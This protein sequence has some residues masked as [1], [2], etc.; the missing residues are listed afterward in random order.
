[1]SEERRRD[2]V[3]AV[4]VIVCLI[5]IHIVSFFCE[6]NFNSF[7]SY[8]KSQAHVYSVYVNVIAIIRITYSKTTSKF[9]IISR[10]TFFLGMLGFM[11]TALIFAHAIALVYPNIHIYAKFMCSKTV[12]II[13]NIAFAGIIFAISCTKGI[14]GYTKENL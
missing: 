4:M 7:N 10:N 3:N 8:L 1:M 14:K 9:D 11:M 5:L 6:D 12:F 2:I 13:Y